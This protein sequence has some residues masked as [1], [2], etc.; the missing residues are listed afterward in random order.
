M[1]IARQATAALLDPRVEAEIG[2]RLRYCVGNR[3]RITRRLRELEDEWDL[4]SVLENNASIVAAL[5]VM[6]GAVLNR[7]VPSVPVSWVVSLVRLA[8]NGILPVET[9]LRRLGLRTAREI[10]IERTALKIMRGDL[11]GAP[12]SMSDR[13]PSEVIRIVRP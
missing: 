11:D 6:V 3:R 4:E 9:L 2:A 8:A 7:Q 5:G 13:Q 10:E 1:R 12:R